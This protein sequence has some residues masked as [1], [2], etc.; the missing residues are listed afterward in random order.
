MPIGDIDAPRALV[1]TPAG[2]DE[3]SAP[4]EDTQPPASAPAGRLARAEAWAR[5]DGPVQKV[6]PAAFFFGGFLWDVVTIG[7]SIR[8]LDLLTLALYYTI[9]ASILVLRGREARFRGSRHLNFLLQFF[10]GNIFSALVV[11]YFISASGFWELAIVSGLVILLVANEFLERHYDKLTLSWALLTI[12]G[13]MLLNFMLPHLFRSLSPIWFYVSTASAVGLAALLNRVSLGQHKLWPTVVAALLLMSL[14]M[15][16]LIPPVPLADKVLVVA[17]DVRREGSDYV[18][19]IEPRSRFAFWRAQVVHRE[20]GARVYCASSIFVPLGIE[21]T[22]SHRWLRLE[23]GAWVSKDV[24]SFPIRGG[25]QNG[26]RGYSFKSSVPQ[27][28]WKV[29]VESERGA[30]IGSLRFRVEERA[31]GPE[32]TKTIRF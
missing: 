28:D 25:R 17:H 31:A 32:R 23:G 16:N 21:T 1:E 8:P 5:G 3:I 27:G 11:F 9:C 2:M 10:L 20:P 13:V 4:P 26:Y 19:T 14:H 15:M 22:V 7:R 24:V 29:E 30:V 18:V 12:S 6:M